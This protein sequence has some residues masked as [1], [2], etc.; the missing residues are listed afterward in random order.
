MK[1]GLLALSTNPAR[2]SLLGV[3]VNGGKEVRCLRNYAGA[4]VKLLRGTSTSDWFPET[5]LPQPHAVAP[6]LQVLRVESFG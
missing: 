6:P 3:A 5:H 4:A 2:L 1:G